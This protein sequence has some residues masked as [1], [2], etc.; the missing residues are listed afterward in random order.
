MKELKASARHA[1]DIKREMEMLGYCQLSSYDDGKAVAAFSTDLSFQTPRKFYCI[2][3]IA[4]R[5]YSK[6]DLYLEMALFYCAI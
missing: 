5:L 3:F 4:N 1:K 2:D 6:S